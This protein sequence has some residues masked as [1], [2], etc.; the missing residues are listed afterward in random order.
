MR[1]EQSEQKNYCYKDMKW[2]SSARERGRERKGKGKER[3]TDAQVKII[4]V[5]GDIFIS[6][7]VNV[8]VCVWLCWCP[9]GLWLGY[10]SLGWLAS[11]NTTQRIK[12]LLKFYY[13]CSVLSAHFFFLSLSLS[14]IRFHHLLFTFIWQFC[15]V[16]HC[17]RCSERAA[18]DVIN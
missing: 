7:C 17:Y 18:T 12:C 2:K 1:C 10:L 5:Y 13:F 8:S 16:F 11:S 9:L 4:C 15:S 3:G 14:F 6:L